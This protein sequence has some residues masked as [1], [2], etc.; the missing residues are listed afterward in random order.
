M[1]S[2]LYTSFFALSNMDTTRGHHCKLFK[3]QSRLL[4]RHNFLPTEK[5]V[6]YSMELLPH[7]MYL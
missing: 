2:I 5:H 3:F 4:V 6:D 1:T 7:S